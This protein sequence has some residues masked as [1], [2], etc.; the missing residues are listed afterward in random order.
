M[1]GQKGNGAEREV[2]KRIGAWWHR[3]EMHAEFI[4]TPMSGGWS[5]ASLRSAFRAAGD[6]MTD[7]KHFPFAVEV[8]RREAWDAERF[9]AGKSSPVWGWWR[10]TLTQAEE[11]SAVPMLWFRQNRKPWWVMVPETYA[12]GLGRRIRER[13]EYFLNTFL[14]EV[15]WTE[16][17]LAGCGVGRHP[18]VF[19]AEQLLQYDP[20]HFIEPK[21]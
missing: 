5:T 4:R 2:A 18:V 3:F 15:Q 20:I 17:S 10:Q 19:D 6:L 16:H 7:S 12:V 11:L 14:F 8:K 1:P 13:S 9:R 21:F